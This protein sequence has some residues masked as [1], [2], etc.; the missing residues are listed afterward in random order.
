VGLG[1]ANSPVEYKHK[2]FFLMLIVGFLET[3]IIDC[4][5][6]ESSVPKIQ[7]L[8]NS[9]KYFTYLVEAKKIIALNTQL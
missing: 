5:A 1:R 2:P 7:V 3:E 9:F 8:Y 4:I 6:E